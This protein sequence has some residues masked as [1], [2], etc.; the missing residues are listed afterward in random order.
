MYWKKLTYKRIYAVQTHLVQG[1]T[2]FPFVTRV[3]L[4]TVSQYFSFWIKIVKY[5]CELCK[6][7][8]VLA[9]PQTPFI[10]HS[11]IYQIFAN[12]LVKCTCLE[13][14]GELSPGCLIPVLVS[15]LVWPGAWTNTPFFLQIWTIKCKE[16]SVSR[17]CWILTLSHMHIKCRKELCFCNP[18]RRMETLYVYI[19]ER[20]RGRER[21]RNI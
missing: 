11:L 19:R 1:S 21:E 14:L 9:I 17:K 2:V 7:F 5:I 18:H 8:M 16:K 3:T 10:I 15:D 20:R 12:C 4:G 13:P 6:S